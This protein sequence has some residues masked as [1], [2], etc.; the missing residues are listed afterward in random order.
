[1][2]ALDLRARRRADEDAKKDVSLVAWERVMQL[3]Y[4]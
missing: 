4:I 2:K 1:M 3:A